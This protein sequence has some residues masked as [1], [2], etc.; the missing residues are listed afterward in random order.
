[1]LK[2]KNKKGIVA[3][4]GTMALMGGMLAQSVPAY[5]AAPA[6]GQ[7][8]VTYDN[9]QVLPDDNAQYG[10]IIP[11]AITFDDTKTQA[12]A[13]VEITGINGYELSNWSELSVQASVESTNSYQLKLNG[14]GSEYA[15]YGLQ[16]NGNLDEF[17]DAGKKDI[18]TKLGT[19]GTNEAK[20]TGTATLKDKTNA[21]KKGQYTDTLTYSFSELQNIKK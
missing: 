12:N 6:S 18:T 1:M 21:T 11:T 20:V 15:T 19:G 7:T 16:Y 5:A 10:M 2:R 9:R 13:D 14:N 17:T 8:P 3:V 4:V